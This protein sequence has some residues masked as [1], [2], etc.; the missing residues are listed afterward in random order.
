MRQYELVLILAPDVDEE[1]LT[2]VMDRVKRVIGDH[3]GEVTSED[4]W[5][6]RKLAYKIGR[7][8]EANYHLAHLQMEGEATQP[9]ETALKLNEEVIRHLLIR[10]D[11]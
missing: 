10:E 6:R 9:L 11:E 7:F 8:T 3:Q 5:G 2:G 4:S 1:R